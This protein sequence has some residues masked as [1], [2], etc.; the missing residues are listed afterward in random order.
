MYLKLFNFGKDNVYTH[1]CLH[2]SFREELVGLPRA[3]NAKDVDWS[4][5]ANSISI[6]TTTKPPPI[7][8]S[9]SEVMKR[10]RPV[11]Q[12]A[13]STALLSAVD[14]HGKQHH[15]RPATCNF[16]RLPCISQEQSGY[17]GLIF[18]SSR[19]WSY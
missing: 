13:D 12:T 2:L 8:I 5:V 4:K 14:P 15:Y 18:F 16:H 11:K 17:C 6:E 19:M 3:N 9:V 7:K 10:A 1:V